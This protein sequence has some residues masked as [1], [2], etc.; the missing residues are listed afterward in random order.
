MGKICISLGAEA[1][2]RFKRVLSY[3]IPNPKGAWSFISADGKG[4]S[5]IDH[6]IASE[7][8]E[9]VG[10]EYLA[11]FDGIVLAGP[12]SESPIS[13]H[14]VLSLEVRRKGERLRDDEHPVNLN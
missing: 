4:R 9:V 13:D 3:T 12:K 6:A 10:A 14:A 5:R 8:L 1:E 11:R 2:V 7:Y